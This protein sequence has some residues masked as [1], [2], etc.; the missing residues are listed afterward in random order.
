MTI[1]FSIIR[2]VERI[3]NNREVLG[4]QSLIQYLSEK[5]DC[6]DEQAKFLLTKLPALENKSMKKMQEMLDFLYTKGFKP[7]H[8][9]RVPKILLHSVNTVAKRLKEIEMKNIKLDSLYM[10]TKSEKQYQLYYESL[11]KSKKK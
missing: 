11:N 10:L 9:Y 7:I 1:Y 5:L 3:N 8:V 4:N 2:Y 6:T